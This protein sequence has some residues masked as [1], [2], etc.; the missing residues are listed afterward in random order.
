MVSIIKSESKGS[1]N[2]NLSK[3]KQLRISK[4]RSGTLVPRTSRPSSRATSLSTV[5][6]RAEKIYSPIVPI[7]LKGKTTRHTPN[8]VVS[9]YEVLPPQI[10]SANKYVTLSGDLFFVNKAPF[11]ATFSDHIK[12]TTAKHIP[13]RKIQ[14]LACAGVQARASR[15]R[16]TRLPP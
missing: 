7:L 14:S 9:D 12:F 2:D 3:L 1:A 13:N 6:D 5:L 8:R 10:L 4:P 16:C 15:L 11:F